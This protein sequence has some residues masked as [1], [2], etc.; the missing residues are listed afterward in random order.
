MIGCSGA[1]DWRLIGAIWGGLFF[2][3]LSFNALVHALGSRHDGYTSLLV[4]GGVLITLLGLA[5]VSWQCA[6]LALAMFAASGTPMIVGEV[7]RAIRK[8]EEV[9]KAL[10]EGRDDEA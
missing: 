3:G 2:F 6:L 4:A 9:L 10:R 1:V 8:R 7:Y 5:L